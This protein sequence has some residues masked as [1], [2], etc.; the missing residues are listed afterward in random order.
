[1]IDID[2][3]C[4]IQ[5]SIIDSRDTTF[6][7]RKSETFLLFDIVY[8]VMNVATAVTGA[9]YWRNGDSERQML[10]DAAVVLTWL[11]LVL[12]TLIL[13]QDRAKMASS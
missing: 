12:L 3:S 13:F 10:F 1:M 9:V 5:A 2:R 8:I 7:E 11:T 6:Y 4:P